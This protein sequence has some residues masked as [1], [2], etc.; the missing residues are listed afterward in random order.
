MGNNKAKRYSEEFKQQILAL[1]N[2]GKSISQL[3]SEYGINKNTIYRWIKN[4]NPVAYDKDKNPI[5]QKEYNRLLKEIQELK[6]ENEILKK[7]TAIFAGK[8]RKK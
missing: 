8:Q 3:C 4:S 1:Y 2:S 5:N 7:A 6:L